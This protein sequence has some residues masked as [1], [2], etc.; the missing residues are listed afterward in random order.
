MRSSIMCDVYDVTVF[1]A[2]VLREVHFESSASW[3]T[4]NQICFVNQMLTVFVSEDWRCA[5]D[6]DVLFKWK[7]SCDYKWVCFATQIVC[8]DHVTEPASCYG[9]QWNLTC[10]GKTVAVFQYTVSYSVHLYLF[11][12]VCVYQEYFYMKLD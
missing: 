7:R 3:E 2:L 9:A 11:S 1:R 5:I 8:V 10:N 4:T 12:K 6:S